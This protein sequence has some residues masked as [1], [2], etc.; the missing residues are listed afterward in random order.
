MGQ[1]F[2]LQYG[3]GSTV[4]GEQYTDTV[5]I[6]GYTVRSV[7]LISVVVPDNQVGND[8]DTWRCHDIFFWVRKLTIPRRRFDGNGFPIDLVVRC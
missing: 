7:Q 5:S 2:S 3:D 4:S 1:T 6:A 8:S